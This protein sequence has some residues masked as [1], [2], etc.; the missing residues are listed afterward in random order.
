MRSSIWSSCPGSSRLA[1]RA[2]KAWPGSVCCP[3]PRP[4]PS[5]ATPPSRRKDRWSCISLSLDQQTYLWDG[6]VHSQT[7]NVRFLYFVSALPYP[8]PKFP[9][10]KTQQKLEIKTYFSG[11]TSTDLN[12]VS[13]AKLNLS[14][15][16]NQ[17]EIYARDEWQR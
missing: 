9:L 5:A 2:G 13:G 14:L 15:S 6:A 16:V 12:K 8:A 7:T 10:C 3:A 4:D 11:E 17:V 1:G